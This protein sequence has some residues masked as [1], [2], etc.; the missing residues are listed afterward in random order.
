LDTITLAAPNGREIVAISFWDQEE[1]ARVYNS[2]SYPEALKILKKILAGTPQIRTFD[3][4]SSTL[5]K[6]DPPKT[7]VSTVQGRQQEHGDSTTLEHIVRELARSIRRYGCR[8]TPA[9]N[10]TLR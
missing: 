4:V 3:V 9:A 10:K 5:Q 6:V 1:N 8:L 7:F 2:T